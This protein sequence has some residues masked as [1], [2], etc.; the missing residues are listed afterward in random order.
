MELEVEAGVR[1]EIGSV[2]REAAGLGM[3]GEDT[4]ITDIMN[5]NC[6]WV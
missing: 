6:D 4:S 1:E 2:I 5:L 3:R